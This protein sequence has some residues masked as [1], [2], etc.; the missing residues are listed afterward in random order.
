MKL[1]NLSLDQQLNL[2][3]YSI[4]YAMGR[5]TGASTQVLIATR[6]V[7][8]LLD[9]E[10][11]KQLFSCIESELKYESYYSIGG[12]EADLKAWEDFLEKITYD[13]RK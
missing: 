13:K 4:R 7:L 11:K 3:I 8:P 10:Q 12:Y 9:N 5:K 6:L 1:N 2:L